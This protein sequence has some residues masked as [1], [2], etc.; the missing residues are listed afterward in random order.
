[1]LATS[2]CVVTVGSVPFLGLVVPNIVTRIM[3]DNLRRSL[4]VVA[5]AGAALTLGADI[6]GRV[7][8]WPYEIPVGTVLGVVGAA[9]FLVLLLRP[10]ARHART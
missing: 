4:P 9:I 7:I 2:P 5:A 1:M 3:G 10:A 6:I 8:R